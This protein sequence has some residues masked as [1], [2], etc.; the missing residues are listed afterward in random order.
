MKFASNLDLQKNEL[1]NAKVQGL[2]G[3]PGSPVE[4]QL[5]QNTTDHHLYMYNGSAWKQ[6]EGY[7][8][9]DAVLTALA[10]LG[11]GIVVQTADGVLAAR[12]LQTGTGIT[13]GNA[14]GTAAAPTIA[15]TSGVLT[16][17]IA[18]SGSGFDSV[19]TGTGAVNRRVLANGVGIAAIT[20]AD[21]VA[22]NPTIALL[23]GIATPGTSTKVTYDT[24]GRVTSGTGL[25]ATDIPTL[26]A[27]YIS[28]F[29]TQVRT[30]TINQLAVPTADFSMNTHKITSLAPPTVSTDAVTKAYVDGLVQGLSARAAVRA[31][32]TVNVTLPAGT[33]TVDGVTVAL[34]DRIL[35]KNQT[36]PA[37]NGI[38]DV[39]GGAWTRSGDSD[40]W[41]KLVSEYVL[42]Q[43]G[44]LY[45]DTGWLCTNDAGGTL[46]TTAVT[47][48]QFSGAGG[49]T[50]G[51]AIV[52]SGNTIDVRTGDGI[53]LTG[54]DGDISIRLAI[55]S[56][57]DTSS[58]SLTVGAGT[59]ITVGANTISVTNPKIKNPVDCA[60]TNP[61][62]I[63]HNAGTQDLVVQ[64]YEKATMTQVICDIVNN[65]INQT[66]ITFTATPTSAQ[67]RAVILG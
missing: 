21:G 11:N 6:C 66:T 24:Y 5:Y 14:D 63:T 7:Q 49:L 40:A 30:S 67:Y 39:G 61:W 55:N 27:S 38:Y 2:S 28:N 17:I 45:K 13:I 34:F 20:N 33:A 54:T 23:S 32:S 29:D 10:A 42:V 65:T 58:G 1:Q 46:G 64:V 9:A 35:L 56:G 53:N 15:I 18:A 8:T 19:T 36:A 52:I 4:G 51:A 59:G 47:F 12:T 26:T 48:V 25:I 41:T 22:G 60:T 3:A 44:T 50:A 57:L 37:E 16:N 31:A 43:Q 62:V